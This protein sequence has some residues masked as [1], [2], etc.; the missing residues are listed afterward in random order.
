MRFTGNE[1]EIDLTAGG[2]KPEFD[3][4]RWA[5]ATEVLDLIVPFK[6]PVYEAVIAEFESFLVF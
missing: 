2:H 4:W 3:A 6:R 5:T 1:S